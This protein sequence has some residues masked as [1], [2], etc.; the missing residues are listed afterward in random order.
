MWLLAKFVGWSLR[1]RALV[2]AA[3]L[4]LVLL[5]ARAAATLSIDAVPDVTNVQVQIITSAP[6]L[7]PAEVEQYVSVPIERAMA[8][9]PKT[10]EVRSISKYGLSVVTVVFHDGTDIYFARQLVNERMTE[11]TEA[12]PAQ[13]GRPELGPISSGL[14]EIYQFTLENPA[15]TPMQ[16]E[17]MLD[18]QIG[19]ALRTVPGIVEVNSFGGEDRQYQVMLDPKRLQA[20][21]VSVAQVVEAL[22]RSN[23]NAGGGYI[24]HAREHFVVGTHGLVKSLDDL[25]S[26]VIGATAQGVPITIATVGDVQFGPRLRRGAASKDGKGE[27]V[28][29]VALMLLGENSRDVTQAVK[30][31]LAQI[32]ASLPAGTKIEAFYDRSALVDRTIKTVATNL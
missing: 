23:A 20:S 7:S 3:A 31:K 5:G 1:N 6:A 32:Q 18:W 10:S 19:P 2:L 9:I 13:Y 16:L 12:V 30:D 26:V 28:V 24:E 8:G 22:E 14:G 15:M 17:E 21:G 11:A 29:G 27:V 25:Q 4:L